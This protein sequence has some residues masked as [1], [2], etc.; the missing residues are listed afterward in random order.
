MIQTTL[1]IIPDWQFDPTNPYNMNQHLQMPNGV[2]QTTVQPLGPVTFGGLGIT[3]VDPPL[4]R[5]VSSLGSPGSMAHQ[6]YAPGRNLRGPALLGLFPDTWGLA[7]KL[8][9][10]A[11]LGAGAWYLSK[12]LGKKR[13]RR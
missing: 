11:A 13:R 10:I 7:P 12:H 5:F 6:R 2:Q 3:M 8:G 4:K 9:I 1:G